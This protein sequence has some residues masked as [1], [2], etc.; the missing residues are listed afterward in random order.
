MARRC[1]IS[2]DDFR[3]R[4]PDGRQVARLISETLSLEHRE[5]S[6]GS[7]GYSGIGKIELPVGDSQVKCHVTITAAIVNSKYA[8]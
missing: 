2:R 8:E 3:E 7:L 4:S 6:T 1:K 5:F